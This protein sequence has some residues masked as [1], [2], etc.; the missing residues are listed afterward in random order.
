MWWGWLYSGPSSFYN[1]THIFCCSFQKFK[2]LKNDRR[3]QPSQG[4]GM[5]SLETRYPGMPSRILVSWS[6]ALW[7]LLAA[8]A[9]HATHDFLLLQDPF[10]I[11]IPWDMSPQFIEHLLCAEH[12]RKTL[13][14]VLARPA[15]KCQLIRASVVCCPGN[16]QPETP[17]LGFW[18][19][20]GTSLFP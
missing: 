12:L 16:P 5:L 17:D 2:F 13:G 4:V 14:S 8:D 6:G 3:D 11:S 1:C 9:L 19:M 15:G 18:Q 20:P 10:L 7:R